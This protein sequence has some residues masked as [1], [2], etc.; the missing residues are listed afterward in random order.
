MKNMAIVFVVLA[1]AAGGILWLAFAHVAPP[2][3]QVEQPVPDD[4]ISR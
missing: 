3:K 1:V 4:H 2:L